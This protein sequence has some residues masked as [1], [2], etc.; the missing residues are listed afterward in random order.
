MKNEPPTSANL[1]YIERV[2]EKYRRDPESVG[3][4]WRI[5]FT[6]LESSDAFIEGTRPS[7]AIG[8]EQL[9]QGHGPGGKVCAG[10][11]RA[12]AMSLLQY[13]VS[14]LI[15]NY[16]VRGHLMAKINPLGDDGRTLPEL[17]PEYYGM[18]PED[19]DLLFTVGHMSPN[20]PLRLREVL[21]NLKDT[22]CGAIGAQFMHIDSL[23]AREWLQDRMEGTR[24]RISLTKAQQVR[25]LERLTDAVVFERFIQRKFVGAKSFSLEGAETLIPLLDQ[26][27]EKAGEQGIDNIVIG[28]PHRGRLNVLANIM[29]KHPSAIFGEFRDQD[30]EKFI[31][32]GDVK[33]HLGYQRTWTTD[34]EKRIHVD[35]AFNPSH[36]EFVGPVAQGALKARQIRH[37]DFHGENGLLILIHGDASIAGEGIV[38]ETLNLS[39]LDGFSVGGT[40]HIVVN[41]QIGFTTLAAEARSTTY[42]SDV[43]KMLQGPIFHVNGEKPDAVAQCLDVCLDFRHRF[44]RDTVIDLYCYRRRGHNEGD[45]PTFT[46]PLMYQQIRKRPDVMT[47]YTEHLLALGGLTREEAR[48]INDSRVKF[49]EEEY[50]KTTGAP[51]TTGDIRNI[52]LSSAQPFRG[53]MDRDIPEVP[54]AV[55]AA[56]LG[57][58]ME[59][60]TTLP[61]AFNANPKVEKILKARLDQVQGARPIDWGCAETL[62]LAS[63]AAEGIPIRLTGQDSQRGTFSHRHSVLHDVENGTVHMPLAHLSPEQGRVDI[64]NSP[65]TEGAVLGFEYGYSTAHPRTLVIWEAQFG[66]FANVAQVYIDQF[67]ASG[68]AKWGILSGVVLLL[69]H[70]L[71]GT[72]PEH[73]SARLERYLSL[74][75][76]DNY[77]VVYPTT[78]AQIFHLLRRQAKRTI[79]KPLVVMSPKSMLRHPAATSD[80]KALA[81]GGFRKIIPDESADPENVTHVMLCTGKIYY[82]LI[83]E[84]EKRDARDVA[85]VRVEQLYPLLPEELTDA[86]AVYP[87]GIPLTWVQEEPLNMGAGPFVRL[88]FESHL[89][90]RWAFDAV[91]RP[92]AA[93]PATGSAASH[94][95]E[96]QII[97]ETAFGRGEQR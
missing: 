48:E 88:K 6:A 16:R 41:N 30:A 63:L 72:G 70:G 93:T 76:T 35:L 49:L 92:E 11:G 44:K 58:L 29:G 75:A 17:E 4:D 52:F 69:P 81:A 36:L 73:A 83:A 15:R 86:L 53:G 5:Y 40:L 10:C 64:V 87:D 82:D 25:T 21:S 28:M 80:I 89:R 1:E 59:K 8:R 61:E 57:A 56:E 97:I 54:T 7:V 65:L 34:T 78:P 38:Q 24:N 46:Q 27:I 39:E 67:I 90:A 9:L 13:N 77:L 18:S 74:A 51:A 32:R 50:A 79:R 60:L 68:E 55:G 37:N 3:H 96:Q 12:A 26:A 94:K 66:D 85:V 19:L 91:G 23:R 62:A 42:A 47:S 71:E 2:W 43:A 33:Y 45:E 31:G 84:R 95:L 14:Q 20:R 22:Y